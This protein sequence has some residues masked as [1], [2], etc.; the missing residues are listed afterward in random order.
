M[1]SEA[2]AIIP[3]PPRTIYDE[4]IYHL[5]QSRFQSNVELFKETCELILTNDLESINRT[6]NSRDEHAGILP[7][8]DDHGY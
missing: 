8:E 2:V 1:V 7:I 3:V 4:K 5:W 6:Y